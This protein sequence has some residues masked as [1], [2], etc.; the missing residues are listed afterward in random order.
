MAGCVE[1][2]REGPEWRDMLKLKLQNKNFTALS[3]QQCTPE[4]VNKQVRPAALNHKGSA[5]NV[6]A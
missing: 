6:L 3:Y 1:T 2:C 4:C 5:N